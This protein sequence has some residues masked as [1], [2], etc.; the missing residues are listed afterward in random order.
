MRRLGHK[1][2]R[3]GNH[4]DIAARYESLGSSWVD[5]ADLGDDRPDGIVGTA[6]V[7]DFVEVKSEDGEVT[8]G[9]ATFAQKWRGSRVFVIRNE[10][11]VLRHVQDMRHRARALGVLS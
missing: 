3:D 11:D 5:C 1:G 7:T 8:P 4:R 10:D 2:R 9:Q 6:G